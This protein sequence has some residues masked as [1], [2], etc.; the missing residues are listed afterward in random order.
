MPSDEKP[1]PTSDQ[2]E[3][4][5][6][7]LTEF[8]KAWI[9]GER[10]DP[11]AFCQARPECGPGLRHEIDELY[12]IL[13]GLPEPGSRKDH[14]QPAHDLP[15]K[16]GH[17][18]ILKELGRGGQGAV[19]LA[20]DE[21]L[22]RKVALKVLTSGV[23]F[24]DHRLARFKR[25]A[26]SASRLNHPGICA[27][28]E[29]GESDGMP[30]IAMQYVE[31]ES[32]S[33]K[34]QQARVDPSHYKDG[35]FDTTDTPTAAS[36]GRDST[37][38]SISPS[39]LGPIFA[40]VQVVEKAARA[41]HAA[42]EAG[43]IH[44][45]IKPGNIMVTPEGDPVVLDFGLA[46][47]EET[48]GPSL[49]KSTD[50][51]GTPAYMSPEQIKGGKSLID[52]ATDI[53]SLAATLVECLTL[54]PPFESHT[55]EGLYRAILTEE[56]PDLR[57][58]NPR[59]PSDLCAIVETALSK[60]PN[61]RYQTAL[62]FAEELRRVRQREPILT[63]RAGPLLRLFRWSQRNPWLAAS[64][65]GII[66]VLALGF[67][68][69][70]YQYGKTQ[71]ELKEKERNADIWQLPFLEQAAEEDLWPA[72]PHKVGDMNSWLEKA[73]DLFG[74][75]DIH[76]RWL[77]EKREALAARRD[78]M[79][80]DEITK[81][82][83]FIAQLSRF[84]AIMEEVRARMEFAT[85]VEEETI[86]RYR[87]EWT[88]VIA[89]IADKEKNPHYR[90]LEIDP[91]IGLIPLGQ[92]SDS[93]LFEF[94]HLQTGKVPDR[95]PVTG[96]LEILE[97]TGLVFV[98]LPGGT[99][100]MGSL[101]VTDENPEGAPY[102]DP[103][104][105]DNEFPLHR[106]ALDPFYLSKFEMTQGQ[107]LRITGNNPSHYCP[108]SKH[109]NYETGAT[110]RNPVE[111]VTW[112]DCKRILDRL[113]MVLPTEAQWEYACRAGTTTPWFT[114]VSR[115]FLDGH[116]N[117][118]DAGSTDG[119]SKG[120]DCEEWLNDGFMATAPVGTFLPNPFGFHN[121]AGN[122]SE[123]C[124]DHGSDYVYDV[125]PGDGERD[126]KDDD[127]NDRFRMWRG[128]NYRQT[129]HYARSAMRSGRL[130]SFLREQIGVRPA[131]RIR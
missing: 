11:E 59:I 53:Y 87:D 7:A 116:A 36:R 10:P 35:I 17:F 13:S 126:V 8:H 112:F 115:H 60:D 33:A 130:P 44:R 77:D 108:G 117:L 16:I 71:F 51:F 102:V 92:D 39:R 128:G 122:V 101:P 96:R 106:V 12:Y 131:M 43:I 45:D 95:D 79:L 37:S 47:M 38:T 90:G 29:T 72:L 30:Y 127:W 121:M 93:R 125:T 22:N 55:R 46:R 26:E 34:I 91:V 120:W 19:Y 66:L 28:F 118:A 69:S 75:L 83:A 2:K 129:A 89:A 114:G 63:R 49:T 103:E 20:Q 68:I 105:W 119:Y 4:I 9:S 62:D 14:A 80:R 23:G 110:L 32:L 1:N 6:A 78:P 85:T 52:R 56:A 94:A 99:F 50:L 25:E 81:M 61:H 111:M 97:E 3:L 5:E 104:A 54:H 82:E 84:D 113:D 109:S 86:G 73:G 21:K 48:D 74:R 31:G 64:L 107:W 65:A 24:A 67:A 27:V 18:T 58:R 76:R 70:T 100:Q 88:A 40:A 123:W 15:E 41:L 124:R 98:L 42:H 57:R